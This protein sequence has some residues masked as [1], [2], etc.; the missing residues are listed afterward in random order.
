MKPKMR[1]DKE[2]ERVKV[3]EWING[4]I[5]EIQRDENHKTSYKGEEKII[6]AVR[7]K[8]KIE[9]C[10]FPHYSRWMSFSYGSKSNLYLKYLKHLIRGFQPDCD[11]DLTLITGLQVKMMWSE[12]TSRDGKIFQHIE[13]IRKIGDSNTDSEPDM[14]DQSTLDEI[15]GDEDIK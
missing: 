1:N 14:D 13:L 10:N 12:D 2:Y 7:F 6:D 9:G 8:F 4:I 15:S 3:D 5:E 11:Y